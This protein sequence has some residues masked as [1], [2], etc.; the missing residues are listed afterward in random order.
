MEC[1]YCAQFKSVTLA[2][3][4]YPKGKYKDER[5][6]PFKDVVVGRH[7]PIF[8]KVKVTGEK[9]KYTKEYC[10]GF[11]LA[12][13]FYCE[14]GYTVS[15]EGCIKRQEDNEEPQCYR[16]KRKLEILEMKKISFFMKRK[17][18]KAEVKRPKPIVR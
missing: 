10:Q 8:K 4:D 11:I 13:M 9:N 16:C 17:R 5:L 12:D 6:C 14:E 18:E 1:K 2:S 3:G 7:D 15:V